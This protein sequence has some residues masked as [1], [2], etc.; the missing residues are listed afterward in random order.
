MSQISYNGKVYDNPENLSI[1]TMSNIGFYTFEYFP[2]D[3][4]MVNSK[5]MV[6]VYNCNPVYANM[7]YDFIDEFVDDEYARDYEEMFE[8]IEHGA[9]RASD[10]FK[11]KS[12]GRMCKVTLTPS[13]YDAEG[14]LEAAIGVVEDV[15][16]VVDEE[17]EK[18]DKYRKAMQEAFETANAASHAKSDFLANMSHD[19][20]TPMNAII[21]MT[22]IAGTHIDDKERVQDCLKKITSSSK[23]LLSLINEVLDMSKIES[24]KIDMAEEDFNLSELIDNLIVMIRPQLVAHGHKLI[25]NINKLDH[26][27]VVGDSLRVQQLFV[28]LMSNAIKYT[29]DGGRIRFAITEKATNQPSVGCYEIEVED[30]GIG[31]DE[32]FVENLFEPFTRAND[33]RIGKIQ[34]TGLGM[35]ITKNIVNMMGGNIRVKSKLNEGTKFTVTLYMKLQDVKEEHYED[36][37]NLY[38]LV[39]DDDYLSVESACGMLDEMGMRTEGVSTGHEAIE[40]IVERHEEGDDFFAVILDWKMPDMDGLETTR[41]I[42]TAVGDDVPIIIISAFDWPEIEADA[43]EAGANAF[44]SKPL[45]KSR[46]IH[47]FN[48]L[49]GNEVDKKDG[50]KPLSDFENIDLSGKR[51]LLVEDNELNLEIATEILNMTKVTVE[52]AMDGDV[53]VDMVKANEKGYYDLIF[54]DVQM[55]RMNGYEATR[56]IRNL[57][58]G[59]GAD[60]PIIAM[61]ANAFS[62][63]AQRALDAGMNEHVSK[64]FDLKALASVIEKWVLLRA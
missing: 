3:K 1:E 34:G 63:D 15:T 49:V 5:L 12:T 47:L 52:S 37:V 6:K 38:V 44:I 36:F 58:G 27:L 8:N 28:N 32:E 64:P 35:A 40:K 30:N 43:R 25:V 61:T 45:F 55:P 10:T 17:R 24:G 11:V 23:H 9:K 18:E 48:S 42:R 54:M 60:V 51:I 7:P 46:F 59:L 16:D 56:I 21:G 19:I 20:R 26:E 22:A 2:K 57:E 62:E 4:V 33:K 39:V 53:A 14:I 31:M 13:L 41:A 50:S 29:P